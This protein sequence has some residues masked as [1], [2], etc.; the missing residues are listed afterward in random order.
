MLKNPKPRS[1]TKSILTVVLLLGAAIGLFLFLNRSGSTDI[2]NSN[3]SANSSNTVQSNTPRGERED[4]KDEPDNETDQ[5][6]PP[7][8]ALK[9][10]FT[11]QAPTA[12][13]DEL[14]NEACEEASVIMANA[15]FNKITS[16][17]APTVEHEINKLTKYQQD[18]FGYYLSITTPEA[19]RMAEEVYDL[20][21]EIVSMSEQNIKQALANGKLVIFPANGQMLG[22]PYFTAPGPIYHMLVITGYNGDKFITNDPGTRRGQDYKYDYNVLEDANGNWSHTAHEVNLSDKRIILISK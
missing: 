19:A 16:L 7:S 3:K 11:P 5:P 10:P 18:T 12:N 14:H 21:T 15:Y 6:I 2:A 13:W 17:P 22:N 4:N 8:L 9:V 20:K 1:V